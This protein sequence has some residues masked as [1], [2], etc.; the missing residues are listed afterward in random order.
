MLE[1][2]IRINLYRLELGKAF[3]AMTPKAQETKE[4]QTNWTTSKLNL[5]GLQRTSSRE[6]K[7]NPQNGR[8]YQQIIHLVR[9]LA[10]H[11]S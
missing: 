10:N 1:E 6:W 7:D 9:E 11:L 4:K 8:K 2:N 5:F 3:L